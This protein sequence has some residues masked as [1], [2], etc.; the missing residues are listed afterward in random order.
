VKIVQEKKEYSHPRLVPVPSLLFREIV[1]RCTRRIP[2]K[3]D[4]PFPISER[5]ARNVVYKLAKRYLERRV[6]PRA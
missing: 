6:R 2:G 3:D 5:Q 1:E 4:P